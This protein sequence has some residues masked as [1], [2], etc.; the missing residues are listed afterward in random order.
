ML[1]LFKITKKIKVCVLLNHFQNKI[2]HTEINRAY[3][4]VLVLSLNMFRYSLS[5][6]NYQVGWVYAEDNQEKVQ[7]LDAYTI[8]DQKQAEP[9]FQVIESK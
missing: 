3:Q 9:L 6:S 5:L 2:I 7:V 4:K 8:I 1:L